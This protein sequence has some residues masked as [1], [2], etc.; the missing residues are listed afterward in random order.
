MKIIIAFSTEPLQLRLVNWLL[1]RTD[2]DKDALTEAVRNR[3][4][5]VADAVS[6]FVGFQSEAKKWANKIGNSSNIFL[7]CIYDCCAN[8]D[9]SF[10]YVFGEDTAEDSPCIAEEES[11]K[12]GVADLRFV[13]TR[14]RGEAVCGMRHKGP[15]RHRQC[16]PRQGIHNAVLVGRHNEDAQVEPVMQV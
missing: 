10:K 14:T 3:D 11:G 7:D 4:K 16:L 8:D 15:R 5:S 2:I 12:Q 9:D 1:G 6:F 13:E